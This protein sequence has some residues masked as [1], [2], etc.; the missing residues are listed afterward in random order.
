MMNGLPGK[1]LR[2]LLTMCFIVLYTPVYALGASTGSTGGA[3]YTT[4]DSVT[5]DASNLLNYVLNEADGTIAVGGGTTATPAIS[6]A[7]AGDVIIPQTIT[8]GATDYTV[9]AIS[10]YAF[11]GCKAITGVSFPDTLLTIGQYAFGAAEASAEAYACTALSSITIPASV[12]AINRRAFGYCTGLTSVSYETTLPVVT[13]VD[14]FQGCSNVTSVSLPEGITEIP[15]YAYANFGV[16]SVTI[17]DLVTTVGQGAFQNCAAIESMTIPENVETIGDSAFS[18][19][20]ALSSLTFAA[21]STLTEIGSSAFKSCCFPAITVPASVES[22]SAGGAFSSN[23]ALRSV[24]FEPGSALT[25]VIGD[26]TFRGCTALTSVT[27][28][29]GVTALGGSRGRVFESCNALKSVEFAAGN[30]LT[31]VA[32]NCF[33]D[34]WA[35]TS[36]ELPDTVTSV[37]FG[38]FLW[39]QDLESAP[40]PAGVT[41]ELRNTF[42]Y[43]ES[44]Q[45]CVVP[46]GVTVLKGTFGGCSSLESVTF[47]E[48]SVLETITWKVFQDCSAL[49]SITIPASVTTIDGGFILDDQYVE[50][51]FQR[52]YSL[53]SVTLE[54]GS[55]LQT[56]GMATFYD[57][58][59]LQTIDLPASLTA[60]EDHAFCDCTSLGSVTFSQE[61]STTPAVIS[62]DAFVGCSALTTLTVPP[63]VG[64]I[65]NGAFRDCTA[66]RTATIESTAT[67]LNNSAVPIFKGCCSLETLAYGSDIYYG[68]SYFR[69]DAK[70][71]FYSNVL[72]EPETELATL[73]NGDEAIFEGRVP[74]LP[75]EA[76]DQDMTW[77]F[78]DGAS[79]DETSSADGAVWS[80]LWAD[81]LAPVEA[82]RVGDTFTVTTL[83][84][85][86]KVTYRV[87]THYSVAQ[88]T[89]YTVEVG[90]PDTSA[91]TQS[92]TVMAVA[93]AIPIDT[94][95][96]TIPETVY[97]DGITYEVTRIGA[98][99]FNGC[100][101]L[102]SVTLPDTIVTISD[103]PL[104][105][106]ATDW[107]DGQ[108]WKRVGYSYAFYGCT[109]LTSIDIP[110]SVVSI[111]N[112][113]FEN[114]TALWDVDFA[115][116]SKLDSTGYA[117]FRTC[118]SLE[119]IVLPDSLTYI[120]EMTFDVCPNLKDVT[121]P[122]AYVGSEWYRPWKQLG[123]G[124]VYNVYLDKITWRC[125]KWFTQKNTD[126]TYPDNYLTVYYYGAEDAAADDSA[127]GSTRSDAE[128]FVYLKEG[129][130]LET[131]S[132]ADGTLEGAI[133]DASDYLAPRVGQEVVWAYQEG[134]GE[135][136]AATNT[137]YAYATYKTDPAYNG[138]VVPER[139]EGPTRLDTAV[140]IA[141][142]AYPDGVD[143]AVIAYAYN[144]PDALSAAAYAG[145]VD[146]PVLLTAQA[147]LSDQVLT[148]IRTLGVDRVTIIG[149]TSAVSSAAEATLKTELGSDNVT[150]IAGTSR[151]DTAL[152]VYRSKLG[153]WGD[154]ALVATGNKFADALS[155]SPYANAAGAPVFLAGSDNS[156]DPASFDAIVEGG[157][158]RVI[159]VGGTAAVSSQTEDSLKAVFGAENVIRLAGVNRYATSAAVASWIV[160]ESGAGFIY[161]NAAV[162]TGRNYP[163]AV[164]GGVL[165]GGRKSVL[166]LFDDGAVSML[167]FVGGKTSSIGK[168]TFLGGQ[169]VF[170]TTTV[171]QLLSLWD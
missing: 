28:P 20:T 142:A 7:T 19:C 26:Y 22:L 167:D 82:V 47:A 164:T 37:E 108:T 153:S 106:A 18:G 123:N 81:T 119:S 61:A 140:E 111:G 67:I 158:T 168:L 113:A 128:A 12:T 66:L 110:A 120:G 59:K 102:S 1:A 62:A 161:D 87:L 160:D 17:D 118:T 136:V 98:S 156:L 114:C 131:A 41:G 24:T 97:Y 45:S 89:S 73:D 138:S 42:M 14:V 107:E 71:T 21:G 104:N 65:N 99:A 64:T 155:V 88:E 79:S 48:G 60:I 162:A 23:E 38:A 55:Q 80:Y 84:G 29:A 132:E 117:A 68:V 149:G 63:S 159:I 83:A 109:A 134:F 101:E 27:I 115:E 144:F 53:E 139:L 33:Q 141:N 31:T 69:T 95:A 25:G 13:R 58:P 137:V 150:R 70:K 91:M 9:T 49:P 51:C 36:I 170:P 94:Q 143:E 4:P 133:P 135:S 8:V 125:N 43:C 86:V 103:R 57:C 5:L 6:T 52:C 50:G 34:C 127:F 171:D 100:T 74:S 32:S 96:V 169:S 15:N 154:T 152:E 146:C 126:D 75:G 56:V 46:A 16:V 72:V 157:F 35:L 105:I 3:I 44:L 2:I 148:A 163:D 10:N 166:L 124:S 77:T 39:C 121:L 116:G 129:A 147:R 54:P 165:Q 85:G 90:P 11:Y 30:Q 78:I 122:A 93:P 76:Y 40:L 92:G 112:G 151:C 145:V 130:T